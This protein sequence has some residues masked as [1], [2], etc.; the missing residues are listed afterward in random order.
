[1]TETDDRLCGCGYRESLHKGTP[2][3]GETYCQL[4]QARAQALA[5]S[6]EAEIAARDDIG[7]SIDMLDADRL[8]QWADN[9]EVHGGDVTYWASMLF[10]VTKLREIADNVAEAVRDIG[11]LRQERSDLLA[12]LQQARQERDELLAK[13]A[14]DPLMVKVASTLGANNDNARREGWQAGYS[15]SEETYG[16]L[17]AKATQAEA[18]LQQAREALKEAVAMIEVWHGMG[19]PYGFGAQA[20]ALYQESPEMKR[21]RAALTPERR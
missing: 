5:P 12:Q 19:M 9:I 20:W 2:A 3:E 11:T 13:P 18:A 21:I 15:A 16:L 8:R 17:R 1:M 4:A 10:L 14:F 7:L 6:R